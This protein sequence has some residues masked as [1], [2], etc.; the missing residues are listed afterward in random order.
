MVTVARIYMRLV[1]LAVRTRSTHEHGYIDIN[2]LACAD[3][4]WA[5]GSGA[6]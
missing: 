6:S 5:Q 1:T 2:C 3:R 4:G